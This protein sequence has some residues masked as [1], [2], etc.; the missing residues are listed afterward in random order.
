MDTPG[1]LKGGSAMDTITIDRG[2]PAVA[3]YWGSDR[4]ALGGYQILGWRLMS[5]PAQPFDVATITSMATV[6]FDR[7][8]STRTTEWTTA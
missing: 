5:G 4:R 7:L 6:D 3:E 1:N 8:P 2:T